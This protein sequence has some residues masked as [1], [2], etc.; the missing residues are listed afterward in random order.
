MNT[1]SFFESE[2]FIEHKGLITVLSTVSLAF[3]TIFWLFRS[4]KQNER[5][6]N[7]IENNNSLVNNIIS[8]NP[9]AQRGS[10][11]KISKRRL[12]IETQDLLYKEIDN[13]DMSFVYPLLDALN[14][15]YDLYLIVMINENDDTNKIVEKFST[16]IEDG[17]VYKHVKFYVYFFIRFLLTLENFVHY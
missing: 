10:T 14:K 13:M 3:F 8:S 15:I 12:T 5:N 1:D 17:I 11:T 7:G 2:F 9:N 6:Q 16:L 4:L